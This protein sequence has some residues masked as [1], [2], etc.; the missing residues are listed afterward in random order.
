MS[1]FY[2]F[3]QGVEEKIR[4][5]TSGAILIL[6]NPTTILTFNTVETV[7]GETE[8]D[9]EYWLTFTIDQDNFIEGGLAQYQLFE[10]NKLKEY[11]SCQIIPNLLVNPEQDTR[12]KYKIIVDGIEA[13]LAGVAT[14]GQRHIQVGDKTIEKYSASQ[15]LSLLNYFQGKLAEEE[16]GTDVNTKTD[17]LT[18]KYYWRGI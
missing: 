1:T 16:S 4:V 8:D 5:Y 9:N 17:Q 14:K 10:D 18:I 7:E 2:K 15:L 11:G 13:M 12:G 6:K 3:T